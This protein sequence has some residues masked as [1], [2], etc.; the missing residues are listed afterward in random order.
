MASYTAKLSSSDQHP[1]PRGAGRRHSNCQLHSGLWDSLAVGERKTSDEARISQNASGDCTA[2]GKRHERRSS[3][4]ATVAGK[5]PLDDMAKR[6]RRFRLFMR[7]NL[8]HFAG[9][10]AGVP[11]YGVCIAYVA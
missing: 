2:C 5:F 3:E 11:E 6:G 1:A 10:A 8:G 4:L 9:T 7:R